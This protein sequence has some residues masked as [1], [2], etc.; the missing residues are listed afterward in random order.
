MVGSG[1]CGLALPTA[2]E[3]SGFSSTKLGFW[4]GGS[5]R[6]E[7]WVANESAG[8]TEAGVLARYKKKT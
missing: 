2:N 3:P 7:I 1:F 6:R 5:G 4:G 8:C